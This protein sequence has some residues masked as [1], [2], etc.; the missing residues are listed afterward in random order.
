LNDSVWNNRKIKLFS[1]IP[2]ILRKRY[3]DIVEK[4]IPLHSKNERED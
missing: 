1:N 2:D 3:D 4:K